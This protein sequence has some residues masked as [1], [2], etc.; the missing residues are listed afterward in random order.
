MQVQTHLIDWTV[1]FSFNGLTFSFQSI[2]NSDCWDRRW[3]MWVQALNGFPQSRSGW[4]EIYII[5]RVG[6]L[7]FCVFATEC[8]LIGRNFWMNVSP[9]QLV[10]KDVSAAG[11][12]YWVLLIYSQ[13]RLLSSVRL[14][15]RFGRTGCLCSLIV[16]KKYVPTILC[17]DFLTQWLD[18]IY[19]LYTWCTYKDPALF[20]LQLSLRLAW[21][22]W[23]FFVSA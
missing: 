3:K 12:G 18:K 11:K 7:S 22:Q 14:L 1:L 9:P 21:S 4:V 5:K 23:I 8:W 15:F 6:R 13:G 10:R 2:P 20:S 16:I 19:N 17:L